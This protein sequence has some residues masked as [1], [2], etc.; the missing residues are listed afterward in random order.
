MKIAIMS[1]THDDTH[2]T[3]KALEIAKARDCRMIIHA[4]DLCSPFIAR[5]LRETGIPAYCVFGNNDGDKIHLAQTV[6]I[7]PS[8]RHIEAEGTSIVVFHEPFI[9]DYIDP[10]RV[11]ILIFGHTHKLMID[12]RTPMKIINPGTVSGVLVKVK[13]FVIFETETGKAEVIEL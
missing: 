9:N 11:D 1:D 7:K 8:P 12:E 2:A 13:S 5:S 6:D 10:E 4:G 3:G